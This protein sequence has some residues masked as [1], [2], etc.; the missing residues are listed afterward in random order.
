MLS[1]S[2]TP[3]NL[4][5][6]NRLVMAPMTRNR[7]SS[8]HVPT[9]IMAEYYAQRA[10]VGLIV[11]EGTSRSPDGLGYARIPALFNTEHVAAWQPVTNAVH[12]KA[13]RMF[14][15]LMHTARASATA[16]L[17]KGARVVGPMRR[18]LMVSS[19]TART[20]T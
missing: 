18:A 8:E 9:P 6:R 10:D 5:L 15:Q 12:A 17:P 14:A 2:Y 4:T 3:G 20:A 19:C 11:S 16:N 1:E 13:G 7:A